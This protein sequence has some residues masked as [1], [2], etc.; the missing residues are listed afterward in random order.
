MSVQLAFYFDQ[1]RCMACNSCT[2]GCK[3]WNQIQPG[4]VNWRTQF[5]HE[6]PDS[7]YPLSMGCNHCDKPACVAAC[8]SGAIAK[9]NNGIVTVTRA[10]CTSV[11]ACV[12]ACPF[13]VPKIADDRQ[14]PEHISGWQVKHP[15]QKCTFCLDRQTK[16]EAPACVK[17]CVGRALDFGTVDT[18][19]AKYPDAVRMNKTDFPYAYKNASAPDTGPNFYVKKRGTLVKHISSLYNGKY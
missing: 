9:D 1:S 5:T 18:I 10:K 6:R 11:L 14:E 13:G 7:F 17:A 8:P 2:V 4:L 19:L 16:G 12:A 15:M 3:D